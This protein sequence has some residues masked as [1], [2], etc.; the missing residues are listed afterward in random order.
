MNY[1]VV[2]STAAESDL[3]RIWLEATNRDRI[4]A[5]ANS[6]NQ[7]L[8]NNPEEVGE[9]REDGRRICFELPLR[10]VFRVH[11]AD[12]IVRVVSAWVVIPGRPG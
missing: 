4:A 1:T 9:S 11:P 7:R 10:V 12:R 6:I 3:A 5:A 8:K 2:W